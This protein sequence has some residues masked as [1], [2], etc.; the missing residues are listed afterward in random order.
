MTA[1][2]SNVAAFSVNDLLAATGGSL[3]NGPL[4]PGTFT[5]VNTDSRSTANNEIFVALVGDR[6]DGHDYLSDAVANGARLLVVSKTQ[7]LPLHTPVIVV[8]DTLMALGSIAR[9][10]RRR[11]S[12]TLVAITGSAGKT[13]TKELVAAALSVGGTVQKTIG[14]LNNRV[15]VPMTLFTLSSEHRFAVIEIGTSELGEIALLT[16]MS[17]PD[18]GV[19]TLVGAAHTEGLGGLAGVLQEKTSL[20]RGMSRDGLCVSFGDQAE[21]LAALPANR[22]TLRYGEG[23]ANDVVLL[24]RVLAVDGRTSA[25]YRV[26]PTRVYQTALRWPG[27]AASLNACAALAVAQGVLGEDKVALALERIAETE[28]AMGRGILLH[29]PSGAWILD[30]TYNANPGSMAMAIRT[31]TELAAQRQGK[32][33]LLLGDMLELGGEAERCHRATVSALQALARGPDSVFGEARV[34]GPEFAKALGQVDVPR[35]HSASSAETAAGDLLRTV[36]PLDV[37]VVKGSRGL[38]MERALP[39]LVPGHLKVSA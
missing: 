32:L 8:D 28:P 13:T 15:G 19:I 24:G 21:L 27:F 1:I 12:G 3:Q 7:R 22:R 11:W 37:V 30:E 36:G 6:F 17:E 33:H 35:T 20:W 14:N 38:R 26:G 23:S 5:G 18:V 16:E 29:A 34:V 39:V 9:A 31:G 25:K 10:F 2:P 4:L